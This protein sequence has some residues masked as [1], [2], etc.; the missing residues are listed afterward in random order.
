MPSRGPGSRRRR[1][2][3]AATLALACSALGIGARPSLAAGTSPQVVI[4]AGWQ[5]ISQSAGQWVPV[6]VTVRGGSQ[7]INGELVLTSVG[8]GTGQ[9]GQNCVTV[10]FQGGSGQSCSGGG[11]PVY[12][13]SGPQCPSGGGPPLISRI[14]VVISAGV[15][16][17]YTL[18]VIASGQTLHA[19]V[20]AGSAPVAKADLPLPASSDAQR[21]AVVSDA[22]GGLLDVIGGLHLMGSPT[23]EVV[24]IP[25]AKLPV[26]AFD[27]QSF[28][29]IVLDQ[30]S[31]E[32]LSPAQR[33]ALELYVRGGGG[34]VVAGGAGVRA[35]IAG[36][37]ASLLPAT[38]G[39]TV[40]AVALPTLVSLLESPALASPVPVTVLSPAEGAIVSVRDGSQPLVVEL[41][42]GRGRVVMVAVDP[43]A[44]PIVSWPG[45]APLLRQLLGRVLPQPVGLGK[46]AVV[47]TSVDGLP[48]NS[49]SGMVQPLTDIAAL[50]LPSSNLFGI[51]LLGYAILAGPAS[52]LVLGRMRRRDLMWVTIPLLAGAVGGAVYLTGLGTRDAGATLSEVRV[53]TLG[54]GAGSAAL[55]E[56]Y[57][58]LFVGRGGS[59][60][61]QEQGQPSIAGLSAADLGDTSG[62]L[63][64][65]QGSPIQL[66]LRDAGSASLH[67]FSSAAY[68]ELG[69]GFVTDLHTAGDRIKGTVVNHLGVPL[70]S[71][72]VVGNGSSVD[73]GG[74]ADGATAKVDLPASF[75]SN[76]AGPFGPGGPGVVPASAS[77]GDR[78][79]R[80]GQEVLDA[81][82]G[83]GLGGPVGAVEPEL[84]GIAATPLLGPTSA[85]NGVSVDTVDAVVLPLN[86]LVSES[87]PAT[88]RIID[89]VT[90]SS[91]GFGG[92][93]AG[94]GAPLFLGRGGS[95]TFEFNVGPGRS[96][97][98]QL[99]V[100][101][102]AG[103]PPQ[104]CQLFQ[105]AG[106]PGTPA[107]P[108]LEAFQVTS[109][110][111]QALPPGDPA[112][113][114]AVGDVAQFLNA[115]GVMLVRLRETEDAT[116][117]VSGQLILTSGT[118][119]GT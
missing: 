90:G 103:G 26:N 96:G 116:V 93:A 61:L 15:I 55:L 97:P 42:L 13:C 115:D 36:L 95:E 110:T 62:S 20:V 69:G 21:I 112:K 88:G 27:L 7:D 89:V 92:P 2:R 63:S 19:E 11:G 43:A 1:L 113:P 49:A 59:F 105:N 74:L 18:D 118:G 60:T 102:G 57:D 75:N 24:T 53:L 66:Q 119:T 39:P 28:A 29:A 67:G 109:G 47:Q 3:A 9:G 73:V 82:A 80:R 111:W 37:P 108:N 44:E 117:F 22:S 48:F 50:Q 85:G 58:G 56:T 40:D 5:G 14:P 30:A 10:T 79:R 8:G 17:H 34:L 65:V 72:R 83:S 31:T 46:G 33:S 87:G 41:T 16:K 32:P 64:V 91:A 77:A 101:C 45:R 51:V 81:L 25:A 78:D 54:G 52:F 107:P 104:G 71:V 70:R 106:G 6:T 68:R 23:S 4:S 35:T 94:P 76:F 86:P 100:R 84:I 12:G 99:S 114:I 38:V 98:A